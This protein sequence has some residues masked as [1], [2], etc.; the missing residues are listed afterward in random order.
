MP[1]AKST[2]EQPKSHRRIGART[3]VFFLLLALVL[4]AAAISVNLRLEL[5]E[6]GRHIAQSR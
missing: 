5:R 4:G 3:I 1:K 6:G 2:K